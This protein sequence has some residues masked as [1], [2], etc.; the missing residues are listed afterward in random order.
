MQAF[1]RNKGTKEVEVFSPKSVEETAEIINYLR[2][3]PAIISISNSPKKQRQRIV[4]VLC[5]ASYALDMAVCKLD[6]ETFIIV[7]K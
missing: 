4:D 3:K 6:K 2:E 7:K 1:S 5:G